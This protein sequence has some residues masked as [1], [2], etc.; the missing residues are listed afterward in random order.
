MPLMDSANQIFGGL[1]GL[2]LF[3]CLVTLG[4]YWIAFPIMMTRYLKQMLQAQRNTEEHL[5]VLRYAYEEQTK[6]RVSPVGEEPLPPPLTFNKEEPLPPPL[7]L[8]E[9]VTK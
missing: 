3:A 1:I 6:H 7:T 9:P 2:F 8:D 5:R 4:I